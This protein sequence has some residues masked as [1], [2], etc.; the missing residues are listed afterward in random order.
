MHHDRLCGREGSEHSPQVVAPWRSLLADH[1]FCLVLA[2][3]VGWSAANSVLPV[4]ESFAILRLTG[5]ASKLGIVL[6]CQAAVALIV[7]LAGGVAGDRWSRGRILVASAAVR[8]IGAAFLAVSLLMH[9]ASFRS[10]L[11]V[12]IGYGCANGFFGPVSTA[13]L[14]DVAP[15]D[16]LAAANALTGGL[17]SA[18]TVAGP[19]IA[20]MIVA[21]LGPGAGFASE[22]AL[23]AVT[24]TCL[25]AA[26]IPA[27]EPASRAGSAGLLRQLRTGWQVYA[28]L[29]WL[30]LLTLQWTAFSLLVLAPMS[31]LGP[32]IALRYLG[33]AAAW[34]VI[35]S[36]LTTGVVAGQ[37]AAGRLRPRRPLLACACMCPAGAAEALALGLGAPVAVIAA[38]AVLA[39]VALG[40]QFL[41]LQTTMQLCVPPAVLARV[42]AL[43]LIGSE[44]GQPAGYALAGPAAAILGLRTFV[45]AA[46]VVCIAASAPFVLAPA[47]RD[48]R[49]TLAR[50]GSQTLA[51]AKPA[52]ASRQTAS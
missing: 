46:A 9:T 43:D 29:R 30:W 13:V 10:L 42:A 24:V 11:A 5:S 26:R 7:G 47:L 25:A 33:G 6:A 12:C 31:V 19:A 49:E 20:G 35:S 18:A 39:G 27:A 2:G 37:F 4:A 3:L 36:C 45:T 8:M 51:A 22:A 23:L 21:V 41:M 15:P 50:I 16:R 28:R 1:R 38:A 52:E 34:G 44:L 32:G 40:L 48:S 17:S 14:P